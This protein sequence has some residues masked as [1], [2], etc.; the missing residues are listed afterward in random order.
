MMADLFTEPSSKSDVV[1][2]VE[3]KR[4]YVSKTVLSLASP[5]FEAMFESDFKEKQNAEIPLPGK[6]YDDFIKFLLCFY[7]HSIKLI[8][9]N[10]VDALLPLADEYQVNYIQEKSEEILLYHLEKSILIDKTVVH[11]LLLAD[12]Y[13]LTK[14]R[15]K[16]VE[17]AASRSYDKLTTVDEFTAISSQAK[18]DVLVIELQEKNKIMSDIATYFI[19]VSNTP[20]RGCDFVSHAPNCQRCGLCKTCVDILIQQ[21]GILQLERKKKLLLKTVT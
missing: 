9:Y 4:V 6:K 10:D 14:A 5:V 12:K 8:T 1:L 17:I 2:I 15:A 18:I 19:N 20:I 13:A 3:D 7:P 21:K 11:I 16:A